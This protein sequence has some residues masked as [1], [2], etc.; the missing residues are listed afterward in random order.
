MDKRELFQIRSIIKEIECLQRQLDRA[1]YQTETRQ[2]TV[3]VKG[4]MRDFPYVEHTIKLTGV[5]MEDY[6]RKV[7]RLRMKLKH[8]IDEL[9]ATVEEA[10]EY[11]ESIKD[12][13]TRL[14]LQ[15][16]FINGLTWEQL[17]AETGIP[18]TTAK[19]KYRKWRD[20]M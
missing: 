13:D 5:D 17:E 18:M 11:I 4:S 19:R 7:K 9:M 10:Q 20:F 16:R 3:A 6:I 8:R 15:L 14:I 1:E 2:T 12:S